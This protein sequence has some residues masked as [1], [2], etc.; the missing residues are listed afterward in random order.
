MEQ[1]H[2]IKALKKC[3]KS[4]N[5]KAFKVL[6]DHFSSQIYG[7]CLRYLRDESDAQD[8]LQETFVT[9]Y[10]RIEDYK[11]KGPFGAWITRIAVNNCL[12]KLRK[13]KKRNNDRAGFGNYRI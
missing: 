10:Y 6:Y 8:I 7:V 11:H 1:P 2:I 12:Q 9:A 13:N 3:Q 4:S 5:P